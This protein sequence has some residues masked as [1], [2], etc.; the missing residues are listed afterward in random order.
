VLKNQGGVSR[1]SKLDVG[2][3]I[4]RTMVSATLLIDSLGLASRVRSITVQF[5]NQI[6]GLPDAASISLFRAVRNWGR[7]VAATRTPHRNQFSSLMNYRR[8]GG[9][10]MNIIVA[11]VEFA[12][13]LPLGQGSPPTTAA[14]QPYVMKYYYKA[15][16]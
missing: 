2:E 14:D 5:K 15:Q 9:G 12:S 7:R 13:A 10:C 4:V 1:I 8:P 6:S 11:L 16:W 3:Y